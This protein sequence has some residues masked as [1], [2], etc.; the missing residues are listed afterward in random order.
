MNKDARMNKIAVSVFKGV[1]IM[2]VSILFL[3][4]FN[5]MIYSPLRKRG[6]YFYLYVI[7]VQI[8]IAIYLWLAFGGN[9]VSSP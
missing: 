2:V 3:L 1:I 7:S 5:A 8:I 9:Y 4:I 6:G